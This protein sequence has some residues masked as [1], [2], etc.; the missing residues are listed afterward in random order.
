M[1][2]QRTVRQRRGR[3]GEKADFIRSQ[4]NS[5]SATQIVEAAAKQG[6]KISVNHVYNL[7]TIAAAKRAGSTRIHVRGPS[8]SLEHQIRDAI[9]EIGLHRAREIL[10]EIAEM[11]RGGS[12]V[13]HA[14]KVPRGGL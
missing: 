8:K 1:T 13:P 12:R 10:E 2:N 3:F 4:S 9:A 14:Y 6:L 11:F 7:R 5:I